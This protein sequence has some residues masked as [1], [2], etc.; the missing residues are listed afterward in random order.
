MP[1]N[2]EKLCVSLSLSHARMHAHTDFLNNPHKKVQFLI[3]LGLT[4]SND[5]NWANSISKLASKSSHRLGILH[6]INS[7]VGTPEFLD[8]YKA[9][10]FSLMEYCSPLW[11]GAPASQLA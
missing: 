6:C 9:L 11:A 10:I 4:V 2:P 1:F 3:R 7:F 8:T 5:L